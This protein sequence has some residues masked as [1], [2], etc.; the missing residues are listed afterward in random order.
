MDDGGSVGRADGDGEWD[1][2]GWASELGALVV[3]V[4]ATGRVCVLRE[5]ACVVFTRVRGVS[6]GG[7]GHEGALLG[8]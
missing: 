1:G 6:C 3:V 4:H 8:P 7:D 2:R 5:G